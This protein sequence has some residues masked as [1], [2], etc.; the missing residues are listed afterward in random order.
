[1]RAAE[2][3]VHGERPS[4]MV[5]ALPASYA[6]VLVHEESLAS[7]GPFPRTVSVPGVTGS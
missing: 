2:D 6:L 5:H 1:V 4:G 3:V 7:H